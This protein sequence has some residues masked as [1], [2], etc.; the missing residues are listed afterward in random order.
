MS[1]VGGGA[2]ANGDNSSGGSSLGADDVMEGVIRVLTLTGD[3]HAPQA[4]DTRFDIYLLVLSKC[5]SR[6]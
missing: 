4:E 6:S 3:R 5:C 1:Q 2:G